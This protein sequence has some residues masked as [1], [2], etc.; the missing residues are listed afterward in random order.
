M[1]D[2]DNK[3]V[4]DKK[5]S[6][7]C[8]DEDFIFN[9]IEAEIEK[10]ALKA[11]EYLDEEGRGL[12]MKALRC[13]VFAHRGAMRLSGEPYITH[14]WE[15]AKI[16][17]S[18]K[19]D[20][21][22]AATGFLHDVI[23]EKTPISLEYIK[24]N[25]GKELADLVSD[26]TKLTN[27]FSRQERE[28][29]RS[30]DAQKWRDA[31]IENLRRI[32]LAMAKDLRVILVKFADR[33]HNLR[34]LDYCDESVQKSIALESLDIF[35]P[36]ASRLGIW[37]FKAEMENLGFKYAYPEEF[38]SLTEEISA[39]RPT[40][41]SVLENV[42]KIVKDKL[43][44]MH[45][46]NEV[47]YR[48][49]HLYSVFRKRVRTGKKLSEVYDLA[50]LRIIVPSVEDCY[51]IFG[52]IHSMW[53]PMNG[54]IKDYIARPKPNNYRC[55]HTTVFGPDGVP[56]EIQIRTVEMHRINEV[57]VAAHWAYKEGR[58]SVGKNNKNVFAQLYPWIRGLFN[59]Q[60]DSS[61]PDIG[62]HVKVE[63]MNREVF[64]FT[65]QGDLIDLK[66]GSTPIDFA[67][68]I[69]TNLGH[70]CVGAIV[71]DRMVPL[72]HKLENADVVSI[73]TSKNGTPS[74]DWLR[75][76]VTHQALSKIRAW[77]KKECRE[78]NLVRGRETLKA[79][80]RKNRM[81]E[82]FN[83]EELMLKTA[84][85]MSF[86]GIDDLLASIGY[87][88]Y[89][90]LQVAGRL[91]N[92]AA[93]NVLN[94]QTAEIFPNSEE[95]IPAKKSAKP[96]REIIVEG[97]DTILTK[98]AHCCTPVPG[99]SIVGYITI[100][101]GISVHRS[102][103]QNLAGLQKSHPERLV[104]CQWNKASA[105]ASA[106]SVH[107][108]V[109]AWDRSGLMADLL[110]CLG[111][112]KIKVKSCQAFSAGDRAQVKMSIEVSDGEQMEMAVRC[113]RSV[114]NVISASRI[115]SR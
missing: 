6:A 10:S 38:K 67:Y 92:L 97:M 53:S 56:L 88:E 43:N 60:R 70:K 100:G 42:V 77:F 108:I 5:A 59:S 55:L 31:S 35:A 7:V 102:G 34:T 74:R 95:E 62:D 86:V 96:G 81:E 106:Y 36:I 72:T 26:V 19:L 50:A 113:L 99:D 87:G 39:L 32:F 111:D 68:R 114:R 71:N 90:A 85:N 101:K 37:E 23:E 65:P 54:R 18:Y 30:G 84:N 94:Q 73:Q 20:A 11:C 64:V 76:C 14:V 83:N 66:A 75:V 57:G 24:L 12:V 104:K 79:E 33:L 98:L 89:S 109:E 48:F 2:K 52:I 45:I 80:L 40:F 78:E 25:F 112:V 63:L 61:D 9:E 13:A 28:V 58:A 21:F 17:L 41:V 15:V 4:Q 115:K 46:E 44:S 49:K 16:L 69:H 8:I 107:I 82:L 51:M 110:S 22:T 1:T 3:I 105:R 93:K 103:C 91:Q 29:R 47:E 27:L